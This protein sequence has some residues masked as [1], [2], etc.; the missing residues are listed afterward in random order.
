MLE[1]EEEE[2]ESQ[3]EICNTLQVVFINEKLKLSKTK[4]NIENL[5]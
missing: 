2:C 5:K 4:T 1:Q 3:Q